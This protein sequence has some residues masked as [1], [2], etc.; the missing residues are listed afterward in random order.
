MEILHSGDLD[1]SN[2]KHR[3]ILLHNRRIAQL[4]YVERK[5]RLNRSYLKGQR[6]VRLYY[7][8]DKLE[9]FDDEDYENY[10]G[11]DEDFDDFT[12]PVKDVFKK[13]Y[14][15][16]KLTNYFIYLNGKKVLVRDLAW[17]FAVTERTI[18]NDLKFLEENGIVKRQINKNRRGRQTRSSYIVN[19]ENLYKLPLKDNFVYVVIIAKQESDWYIL[20]KKDKY[21]NFYT[22]PF[23]VVKRMSR[24]NEISNNLVGKIL[25]PN[26]I[27]ENKGIVYDCVTDS[28]DEDTYYMKFRSHFAVYLLKDKIEINKKYKWLKI[29]YATRKIKQY[30][31]NK[32]VRFV[33]NNIL[34][35]NNFCKTYLF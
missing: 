21:K 25:K 13:D 3:E 24:I 15:R 31:V 32:G 14:R 33:Q 35:W 27:K 18:Q 29:T 9:Y 34:G 2:E 16:E 26:D 17:K 22:L 12:R 10:D 28:K 19:K 6:G 1:F 4:K 20:L 11:D 5:K 7:D 8:K 23:E 30:N